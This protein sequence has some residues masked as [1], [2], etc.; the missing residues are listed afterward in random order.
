MPL[1]ATPRPQTR[2]ATPRVRPSARPKTQT[3]RKPR[4]GLLARIRALPDHNLLD[5]AIRGRAWIPVLGILLTLIVGMQVEVLK[6]GASVGRNVALVSELQSRNETLQTSVAG[7]SGVG[8]IERLATKMG[9]TMPGPSD[10]HFVSAGS[11]ATVSKAIDGI[12]APAAQTF[13]TALANE[14]AANDSSSTTD[15]NAMTGTS[16]LTPASGG[17]ATDGAA[18]DATTGATTGDTTGLTDSSTDATDAGTA[19]ADS[20]SDPTS[21]YTPPPV[22]DTSSADTAASGA[23]GGIGLGQ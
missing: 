14:Y 23:T 5:S 8:R 12:K 19:A 1:P 16:D 2:P 22:S 3:A 10:M 11:A 6:L 9:M 7:L 13:L 18:T 17:A 4:V 20:T 21:T 15:T